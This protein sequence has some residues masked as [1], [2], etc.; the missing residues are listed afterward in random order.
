MV[1]GKYLYVVLVGMSEGKREL[2]RPRCRWED[3]FK[4]GLR[5]IWIDGANWIRL[6]QDRLQ[7]LA[8]LSTVMN[9]GVQ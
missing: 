5:E 2:G 3:K 7:W 8:V 4:L 6:A 1:E 9:L